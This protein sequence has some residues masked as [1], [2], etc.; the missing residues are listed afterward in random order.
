[1]D[2]AFDFQKATLWRDY[3]YIYSPYGHKIK[4]WRKYG[5]SLHSVDRPYTT[6]EYSLN[7]RTKKKN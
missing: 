1:M 4:T 7:Q 2:K 3:S 6:Y 5:P